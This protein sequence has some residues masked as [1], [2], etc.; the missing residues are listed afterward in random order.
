VDPKL[1]KAA[2]AIKNSTT[3][4][5]PEW[6]AILDRMA[7]ASISKNKTPLSKRMM[8][9]DVATRWNYTYEMLNFAYNY[10]VAYNELTDNRDMKIRK[11]ELEESDWEIVKQLADVLKVRSQI[12]E[13][14]TVFLHCSTRFLKTLLYFFLVQHPT[15]RRWFQPWTISTDT[16]PQPLAMPTTN[17]AF[18]PPL[19]WGRNFLTS[20][21]HTQTI[22]SCTA[23]P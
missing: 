16:S 19:Q 11:Y 18:K 15:S 2:H 21:T 20:I 12:L 1:R 5:L 4:I 3:I 22:L 8:P 14:I 17:H 13:S 10:R 23:L 9:R 6:W 7:A